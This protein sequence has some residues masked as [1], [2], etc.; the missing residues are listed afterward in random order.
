MRRP[1]LTY[2]WSASRKY[3]YL[4][5]FLPGGREL[6]VDVGAERRSVFDDKLRAHAGVMLG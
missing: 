5:I 4:V 3:A 2:A 1:K 6:A